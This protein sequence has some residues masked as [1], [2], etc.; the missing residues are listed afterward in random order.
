MEKYRFTFID[1]DSNTSYSLKY[2]CKGWAEYGVRY[3]RETRI[4]NVVKSYTDDWGFVKE[5]AEWLVNRL[6]SHGPNRRI[7]LVV[8]QCVDYLAGTYRKEYVGYVDLTQMEIGM[9]EVTVPV[10]SGGFF[11]ALENKWGEVF[12]INAENLCT[13]NGCVITETAKFQSSDGES[14]SYPTIFSNFYFILGSKITNT[15]EISDNFF[16]DTDLTQVLPGKANADNNN[17]MV[18]KATPLH[19]GVCF[20]KPRCRE[21]RKMNLKGEVFVNVSMPKGLSVA[22]SSARK[23]HNHGELYLVYNVNPTY[24]GD[25]FLFESN[26][27][28]R[29]IKIAE[30]EYMTN[31]SATYSDAS[32][33][34]YLP[35]AFDKELHDIDTMQDNGAGFMLVLKFWGDSYKANG[36]YLGDVKSSSSATYEISFARFDLEVSFEAQVNTDKKVSVVTAEN[37]FK[38][39]VSSINAG[40]YNVDVDTSAFLSVAE[41]DLLSSGNMLKKAEYHTRGWFENEFEGDFLIGSQFIQMRWGDTWVIVNNPSNNGGYRFNRFVWYMNGQWINPSV[42]MAGVGMQYAPAGYSNGNYYPA[43]QYIQFDSFFYGDYLFTCEVWGIDSDGN[44]VHFMISPSE[45]PA[46]M[47]FGQLHTVDGYLAKGVLSTSLE[48]FLEYCYSIYNYRLG[49][50]YDM[51]NDRYKV[52]LAHHDNM[53]ST[54]AIENLGDKI[55]DFSMRLWREKLYTRIKIGHEIDEDTVNKEREF[56]CMFEFGTPN[57]EIEENT[58]EIICPYIAYSRGVEE[59]LIEHYL[60]D[61]DGDSG[62]VFLIHGK[63]NGLDEFNNSEKYILNRNVIVIGGSLFPS[64]EWNVR[65]SPKRMLMAHKKE[66]NGYFAFESGK[67]IAFKSA[68]YNGDLRSSPPISILVPVGNTSLIGYGISN[69]LNQGVIIEKEDMTITEERN[70]L[71]LIVTVSGMGKE[72]L[73]RK[74]ENN[75]LG[76]LVFEYG[77]RTY[78][79]YLAYDTDAVSINPMNEQQCEFKILLSE[80]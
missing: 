75:R 36:T 31:I 53:F 19:E 33:T 49:V 63:G 54:N 58:L 30:T 20:F 26:P 71:P 10:C 4:S 43:G 62:K 56:N 78:K 64:Y 66:L 40:R 13:I 18:Y 16:I 22:G 68:D 48:K 9:D 55:N 1:I 70:F 51:E 35:F 28:L 80:Y 34:F 14:G 74:I 6:F 45:V 44:D 79:G 47:V 12:D 38:R 7:K 41:N 39:L 21:V 17:L 50:D 61:K 46:D 15:D 5:D 76:F 8:E 29:W 72:G 32:T 59:Y 60:S 25:L 77:D 65:Y 23:N 27:N 67:V 11:K 52:Y 73:I 69:Q 57:T 3:G 2:G 42:T 37:V 24:S